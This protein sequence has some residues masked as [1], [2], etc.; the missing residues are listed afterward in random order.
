MPTSRKTKAMKKLSTLIAASVLTALSAT[1]FA[2]PQGTALT[3]GT[4]P[5][6][7][8][9]KCVTVQKVNSQKIHHK[10]SITKADIK[11]A[12]TDAAAAKLESS[13]ASADAQK[14]K[15]N[16]QKASADAHKVQHSAKTAL[17]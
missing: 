10:K 13:K 11:L 9:G 3:G 15:N 5:N 1:A 16:A 12:Q 2:C 4:G 17:S 8:G 6:H 7:S 14:A